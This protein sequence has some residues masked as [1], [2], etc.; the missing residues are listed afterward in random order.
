MIGVGGEKDTRYELTR[1]NLLA[2]NFRTPSGENAQFLAMCEL[3][4]KRSIATANVA[5][6]SY[7]I[8]TLYLAGGL[9]SLSTEQYLQKNDLLKKIQLAEQSNLLK[10]IVVLSIGERREYS[11]IL[12]QL[13]Y[14]WY[15]SYLAFADEL[16]Q[17]ERS[18]NR[19]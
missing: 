8:P 18:K 9:S 2:G 17:R 15:E 1:A 13:N 14:T 3:G 11:S 19:W 5:N 4:R 12:S 7:N 10:L 16:K 6:D